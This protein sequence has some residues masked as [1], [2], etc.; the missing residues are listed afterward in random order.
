MTSEEPNGVFRV[1]H[2]VHGN[3]SEWGHTYY[4]LTACYLDTTSAALNHR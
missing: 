4:N 1:E 2:V 3:V